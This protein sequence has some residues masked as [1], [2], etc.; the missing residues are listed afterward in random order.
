MRVCM[1]VRAAMHNRE[2]AARRIQTE[3]SNGCTLLCCCCCDKSL[4]F[5]LLVFA[6][7]RESRRCPL[8]ALL[9]VRCARS[10]WRIRAVIVLSSIPYIFE[11]SASETLHI[12][13]YLADRAQ[14]KKHTIIKI[15]NLRCACVR[16]RCSVRL[17]SPA[18]VRAFGLC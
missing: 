7:G 18:Y 8:C 12:P 9:Y 10:L 14:N 17:S 11:G 16:V 3:I 6:A 4:A 1:C 13:P 15:K 5:V 2:P